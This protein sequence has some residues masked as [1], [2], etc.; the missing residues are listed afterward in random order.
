[1]ANETPSPSELHALACEDCD[2][3][4]TVQRGH[5]IAGPVLAVTVVHRDT[6]P[7]AVRCVPV[8]GALLTKPGA[9]LRHVREGEPDVG[10][11]A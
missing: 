1:M 9:L 3:E 2:A 5:G 7:W 8:G 6:C 4:V 10:A 11:D